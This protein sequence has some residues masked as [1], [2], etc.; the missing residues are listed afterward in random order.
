MA[1]HETRH[2][3]ARRDVPGFAR[4]VAVLFGLT[5]L[6]YLVAILVGHALPTPNAGSGLAQQGQTVSAQTATGVAT[7]AE[8]A[9]LP[10]TVPT[11]DFDYFP[12]HYVNQATK[13]EDPIPTF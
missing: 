3:Y 12:D 6:G 10:A 11:Q 5:V 2:Y 7:A 1:L 13:I 8:P 9:P 4:T